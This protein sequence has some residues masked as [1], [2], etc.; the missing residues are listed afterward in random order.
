MS[1]K[2]VS[3]IL[4]VREMLRQIKRNELARA[5]QSVDAASEHVA[6]MDEQR[7]QAAERIGQAGDVE[8][9]ELRAR[10]ELCEFAARDLDRAKLALEERS[11]ERD[12]QS[13]DM[14]EATRE[15]RVMETLHD[16]L[17]RAEWREE[18]TREQLQL[19]EMSAARR[20]PV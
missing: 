3:R 7:T 13:N 9:S 12:V 14:V 18:I 8:G 1:P 11:R 6:A 15:V 2:S 19:D 20:R 5:N 16:K 10:A 17:Q 4:A